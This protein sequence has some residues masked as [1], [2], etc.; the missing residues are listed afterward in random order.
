MLAWF[1]SVNTKAAGNSCKQEL[2]D[3]VMEMFSVLSF[4]IH[5][6]I[7]F[8]RWIAQH[9]TV[10]PSS[11][12]GMISVSNFHLACNSY[13]CLWQLLIFGEG[14]CVCHSLARSSKHSSVFDATKLRA[15]AVT[16]QGLGDFCKTFMTRKATEFSSTTFFFLQHIGT[17]RKATA[18]AP[19]S[20]LGVTSLA[21]LIQ[22]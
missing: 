14:E 1:T 2:L 20:H 13:T 18:N 6:R 4:S 3:L 22:P 16:K 21:Q 11:A 12:V 9:L 15:L 19:P 17:A 5:V 8:Y 7:Y 10:L